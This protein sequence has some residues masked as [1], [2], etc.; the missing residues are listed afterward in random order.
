MQ[1]SKCTDQ[2]L[3]SSIFIMPQEKLEK[4][5]IENLR[6]N[7]TINIFTSFLKRIHI[8]ISTVEFGHDLLFTTNKSLEG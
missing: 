2:K 7:I 3:R 6:R 5:T 4:C 1:V 8:L